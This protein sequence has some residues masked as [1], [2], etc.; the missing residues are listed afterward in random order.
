MV[1]SRC[2]GKSWGVL[3]TQ[4]RSEA[5]S[6]VLP[7]HSDVCLPSIFVESHFKSPNIHSLNC[8]SVHT[9]LLK[10]I[11][12]S[13]GAD[14]PGTCRI[15]FNLLNLYMDV[16]ITDDRWK[17]GWLLQKWQRNYTPWSSFIT[18]GQTHWLISGRTLGGGHH[19]ASCD[20]YSLM[21]GPK[22]WGALILGEEQLLEV[23]DGEV[24]NGGE[25]ERAS[26]VGEN[27][28]EMATSTIPWHNS[29]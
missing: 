23:R 3:M 14:I 2:L 13:T 18:Q 7:P 25:H 16:W 24:E 6:L 20:G 28:V 4:Q 21:N 15:L 5:S 17:Q 10:W 26:A 9:W 8:K 1:T 12:L 29:E 22:W 19:V 27:T 11:T